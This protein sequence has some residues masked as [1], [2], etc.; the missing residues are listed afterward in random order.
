VAGN[1]RSRL[2]LVNSFAGAAARYW[3]LIF[4]VLARELRHC[5]ERASEIVDPRLRVLALETQHNERG[6]L[7]GAA[8]FAVLVPH[9]YRAHSVRALVTFQAIYD[10][11]DSL[12]EQPS[13]DPVA[14]GRQLHLALLTAVDPNRSHVNYY[15]YNSI[16]RDDGYIERLIERCRKSLD[17][18]PSYH[19]VSGAAI[20]CTRRMVDYQSLNHGAPG[21]SR[22]RLARWASRTTPVNSGLRWWE[23]AAGAA[24]SLSVFSLIAAAARPALDAG[25]TAA[26][27]GAYFPWIGALHVLLDSLIDHGDDMKSGDHSLLEHYASRDEAARRLGAIARQAMRATETM[28]QG[29]QHA[30]ILAS[31]TSFYLSAPDARLPT[32]SQVAETVL[33]A[34]GDFAAPT[35]AVLR[36]RRA[37]SRMLGDTVSS[38]RSSGSEA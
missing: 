29:R 2:A 19:L 20:R 24:S 15:K 38:G 21:E 4:P 14:N 32:A 33:E 37:A 22:H 5:R 6:N 23:T 17:A 16:N 10:Y 11:V 31:M 28:P 12:A 18:L 13:S 30:L 1:R 27:E 36:A 26:V 35:M 8:A 34:M 7:E 9:T 25:E 3:L